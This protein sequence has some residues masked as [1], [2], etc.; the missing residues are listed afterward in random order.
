[1]TSNKG[2]TPLPQVV[3]DHIKKNKWTILEMCG[4]NGRNALELHHND[5]DVLSF[6]IVTAN[7]YIM[8]AMAGTIEH[9]YPDRALLLCSALEANLSVK[10]YKKGGGTHVIIGGYLNPAKRGPN[11]H[12]FIINSLSEGQ[13]IKSIVT[14]TYTEIKHS[15]SDCYIIDVRPDPD[16]MR[17]NGWILVETFYGTG[18]TTGEDLRIFQVWEVKTEV[19]PEDKINK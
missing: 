3:I 19:K 13:N 15:K 10:S 17:N 7:K 18:G 2:F 5:V 4:G 1:M 16:W 8:Y 6:D 14:H 11:E 12:K 9:K